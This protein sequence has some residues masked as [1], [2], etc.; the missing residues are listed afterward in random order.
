MLKIKIIDMKWSAGLNDDWCS[1]INDV[2]CCG[3]VLTEIIF[4]IRDFSKPVQYIRIHLEIEDNFPNFKTIF[5][6]TSIIIF[7]CPVQTSEPRNQ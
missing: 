4:W 2:F 5:L 6:I 7:L 1:N 3:S